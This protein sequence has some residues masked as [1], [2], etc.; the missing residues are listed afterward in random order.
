M[1]L[2]VAYAQPVVECCA[3]AQVSQSSTQQ[4]TCVSG[5]SGYASCTPLLR[6]ATLLCS[7]F[8]AVLTFAC[9]CRAVLALLSRIQC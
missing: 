6:A 4:H 8:V 2:L 3:A 5:L 9:L 1:L 7:S